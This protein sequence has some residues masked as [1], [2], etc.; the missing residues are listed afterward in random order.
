MSRGNGHRGDEDLQRRKRG[1]DPEVA[2]VDEEKGG[3]SEE[4]G[5]PVAEDGSL[6]P[7]K[8]G[9]G[10]EDELSG[11]EAAAVAMLKWSLEEEC[12]TLPDRDALLAEVFLAGGRE[13]PKSMLDQGSK[14]E[15]DAEAEAD[16]EGLEEK[17]RVLGEACDAL[18]AGRRAERLA[19]EGLAELLASCVMIHSTGAEQR[20]GDLLQRRILR[21]VFKREG[22]EEIGREEVKEQQDTAAPAVGG[23]RTSWV[24][25][26][27]ALAAAIGAV[28]V[29]VGV[30]LWGPTQGVSP[31]ASASVGQARRRVARMIPGPF[32]PEQSASDRVELLYGER[33]RAHRRY[34]LKIHGV[35]GARARKQG[36]DVAVSRVNKG[37]LPAALLLRERRSGGE[38]VVVERSQRSPW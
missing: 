2:G 24:L 5:R 8:E 33:L 16:D 19:D 32:P 7:E 22:R 9:W 4:R 15:V 10:E 13:V 3:P 6:D 37:A 11:E 21:E 38:M 34:L 27:A 23:S 17:A 1:A 28:V 12:P 25:G 26:V 20:L 18:L 35:G 30:R 29:A 14:V 36:N 31:G